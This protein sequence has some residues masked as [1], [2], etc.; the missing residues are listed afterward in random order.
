MQVYLPIAEMSVDAETLIGLGVAVGFL[1]GVFGVGGGFLTTPFLIFMGLPP[2][3]AV[4]TQANQLVATSITGVLGHFRRGNVD[5]RMGSVMLA[6]GMIG[7]L[8]G[9]F[10]FKI[11]QYLG[12]ID[13][14]ISLLYVMLL[15]MIGLMMLFETIGGLIRR[16]EAHVDQKPFYEHPFFQKLPYKIRF[17]KSRLYIS[18]LLPLGVGF[19][20]G[21]LISILGIGG[22]FLIVPAMIYIL[23]MPGLLVPGTSLFQI[24]FISA[25]SCLLHA[26]ANQTVDLVLAIILMTGGVIG[27]Q[28]GVRAARLIR[29]VYARIVL[30]VLIVTVCFFLAADLFLPPTDLYSTEVR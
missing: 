9:I 7:A 30:A 4:G 22:G 11:L 16:K 13:V 1:S 3:V 28:A 29:G 26:V 10:I 12:Q 2:A 20:G 5:F 8:I 17:T 21:L 14:V 24:I 18:A 27:A 6:G 23:G 15:G 25:F 19:V